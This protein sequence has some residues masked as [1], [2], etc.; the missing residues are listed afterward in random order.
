MSEDAQRDASRR[1]YDQL[2]FARYARVHA[3]QLSGGT[4]AKL[5]LALA[6]LP[7]PQV[8]LLDEPYAG[9]DF[10][11]YLRFWDLVADLRAS[12]CAVL[13]ISH[14]VADTERFDPGTGSSS[15]PG[16]E[17]PRGCVR[18]VGVI[19]QRVSTDN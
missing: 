17:Y 1:L 4:L 9:F 8:L 14:F 13:V 15:A 7:T 19:P 2:G 11:T 5:N 12:G 18:S 3:D 16:W 10:D 6:L